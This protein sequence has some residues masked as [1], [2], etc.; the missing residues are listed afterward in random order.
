[1]VPEA[2]LRSAF[3]VVGALSWLPLLVPVAY[4]LVRRSLLHRKV[5]F[6]ALAVSL[7]YGLPFFLVIAIDMPL[8]LLS[9]PLEL[10]LRELGLSGSWYMSLV[11]PVTHFF[12]T[13]WYI[14]LLTLLVPL[15]SL[16]SF[17]VVFSLGKRWNAIIAAWSNKG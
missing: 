11:S 9:W 12:R 2:Q 4:S 13:Y 14:I 15:A 3:W 16:W 6:V 17:V 8:A 7:T 10:A 1:M 5:L